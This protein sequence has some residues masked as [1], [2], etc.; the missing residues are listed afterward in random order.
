MNRSDSDTGSA[1]RYRA[2][3]RAADSEAVVWA[4]FAEARTTPAFC[5]AWLDLL[6]RQ[7]EEAVLGLV[8]LKSSGD[9]AY[10]PAAIWPDPV[11][12]VT[13]LTAA[14]Q[15]AL[16]ERRGVEM[17]SDAQGGPA[18]VQIAV[19]VETD[20]DLYGVVV[21]AVSDK[22]GG[23]GLPAIRRRLFW[24]SAWLANFFLKQEVQRSGYRVE[25]A[26]LVLDLA[27][28]ALEKRDFQETL[29]A[30][31][32]ALAVKLALRRASIGLEE[33]GQLRI[34]AIS[35]AAHFKRQSE[36]MQLIEK[37]MEE[38]FDQ[39]RDLHYPALPARKPDERR[40]DVTIDHQRLAEADSA[41]SAASFLLHEHG[42]PF[43]VITLEYPADK[44]LVAE[45]LE[46]GEALARLLA[47]VLGE[48]RELD[49][50]MTGKLKFRLKHGLELLLGPSRATYKLATAAGVALLAFL[51]LAEGEFRVTAKTVI[52][53]LV[54]RAAVAPFEGYIGQAPVRAGD[55]VEA[56]QV[57]ATLD[58][59]DL[60][61]EKIR[62][63]SEREQVLRK[64]RDALAK[65]D[66]PSASVLGAQLNQTEA[67]L[68]LIDE[69]LARSTIRAPFAGIVVSGDLS[70]MLG[71]PVEQGKVL[72]EIAP[73]DAYRVILKVDERDIAYVAVG[74]R[75]QS[76]LS[77]I[78]GDP[79]DFSI[80]RVT[81]VA[82]AEEGINY[83]RVEAELDRAGRL[84]RPGMEG[85]GKIRAGEGKL[86]WIW[87]R[88]LVDWLRI[89]L[90]TW[91][92]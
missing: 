53:G 50:W 68:D 4:A 25:R 56:G 78:S 19:P 67:Q 55:R 62:L 14:A 15:R 81:P 90:W 86:A 23:Y 2:A 88:R 85:I 36:S 45:N 89:G 64:Y 30:L 63:D 32:N 58:D 44:R 13:A 35:H 10:V 21:M 26:A 41:S 76:A 24:G 42:R 70:Q 75:G 37:A 92:P 3:P 22:A 12:D 83:F 48:K 1:E 7:I 60:Q 18:L 38:A 77:G 33:K 34:R 87:T 39:R 66:R 47:P 27:L 59:K 73:L 74:Q 46:L 9:G 80:K 17:R 43:G 91:L 52:E 82:T 71:A 79:M 6:A 69:K 40:L 11:T 72:F 57:I 65:H 51:L 16:V 20:A 8:L 49:R 84:L 31:M 29:M 54:Q 61:L 28:L 5:Q